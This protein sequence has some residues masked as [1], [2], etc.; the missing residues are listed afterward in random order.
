MLV[1]SHCHL[2]F[3]DFADE[4]DAIVARAHA[5]GVDFLV[6]IS[7]RVRRHDQVLA[8]AERFIAAQAQPRLAAE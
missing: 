2:D 4:T 6:T 1:D 5:Q 3:P 8:I 7:T